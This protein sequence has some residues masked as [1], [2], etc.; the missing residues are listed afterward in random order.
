MV[1]FSSESLFA[2]YLKEKFNFLDFCKWLVLIS[3]DGGKGLCH[4]QIHARIHR[5]DFRT[6]YLVRSTGIVKA[7][8]LVFSVRHVIINL[9]GIFLLIYEYFIFIIMCSSICFLKFIKIC[10]S[11]HSCI[12][13]GASYSTLRAPLIKRNQMSDLRTHK[14]TQQRGYEELRCARGTYGASYGLL[15]FM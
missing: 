14:L 3:R 12:D 4:I 13:T 7:G 11:P 15:N 1:T 6:I 8:Q 5:T 2:L 10:T 9:S